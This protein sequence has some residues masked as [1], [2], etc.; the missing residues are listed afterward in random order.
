MNELQR[1]LKTLGVFYYIVGVL[2][3]PACLIAPIIMLK[4]GAF[5]KIGPGLKH[6]YLFCLIGAGIGSL[7]IVA[8]ILITGYG[9]RH[10][11]WRTF[12]FVISILLCFSFPIG[13][14]M[15][16]LGLILLTK[17]ET[18]KLFSSEN[19][20]HG[21]PDRAGI[22]SQSE[23]INMALAPRRTKDENDR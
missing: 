10:Q 8:C 17:P 1:K 16:V 22:R 14:I 13:T 23:R 4:S 12:C 21:E 18:K 19:R 3:I 11:R 2:G 6:I 20:L 9:L 7:A 5:E 15:G